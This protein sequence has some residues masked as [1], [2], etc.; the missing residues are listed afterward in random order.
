VLYLNIL[1]EPDLAYE[2]LQRALELDPYYDWTYGLLGDYYV[3]FVSSQTGLSADQKQE[4]SIQAAEYYSQALK[5]SDSASGQLKYNYAVALGGLEAQL[6]NVE[7]AISAYE[8]AMQA[9]P[10][11]SDRWRVE[12]TLARLYAQ[13]GDLAKA[14]QYAQSA[15]QS[16]PDDQKDA[17]SA[18]IVQLGG[19]P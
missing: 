19:Q 4:A 9:G 17:V 14:L 16:A 13:Q 11:S 6:Q 1:K 3:R 12:V 7:A 10:S 18:L 5:N 8:Q 2:K 15:L